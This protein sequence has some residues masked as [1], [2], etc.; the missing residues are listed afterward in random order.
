MRLLKSTDLA[1]RV[2]LRLAHADGSQRTTA[3]EV[4]VGVGAPHTHVAKVVSRLQHLGVVEARRGRNGGLTLTERGRNASVGWIVRA[5]EGPGDVVG[6]LDTPPCPLLNGCKLRG[7][8]SGAKEAFFAS[9]DSIIV[10]DLTTDRRPWLTIPTPTPGG[11]G[12][13]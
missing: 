10:R 5:L 6:C 13:A 8:L 9:L 1:L 11:K 3:K 12:D 2:V 7:A 4:A